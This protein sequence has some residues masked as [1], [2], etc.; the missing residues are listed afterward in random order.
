MPHLRFAE[1]TT[2]QMGPHAEP[3]CHEE[4]ETWLFIS[5]VSRTRRFP[6]PSPVDH[7]RKGVTSDL[8]LVPRK[9]RPSTD[10]IIRQRGFPVLR[11]VSDRV[12][13]P[14]QPPNLDHDGAPLVLGSGGVLFKPF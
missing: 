8:F 13:L 12:R 3:S 5:T 7:D 9:S 2:Q 14:A 11:P 10:E 1:D 4:S 6:L